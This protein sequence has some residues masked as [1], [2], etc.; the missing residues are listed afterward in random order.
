MAGERM[1]D[2]AGSLH[3]VSI[4]SKIAKGLLRMLLNVVLGKQNSISV[5]IIRRVNDLHSE[6]L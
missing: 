4:L 2:S 6:K 1:Y 3:D 5:L